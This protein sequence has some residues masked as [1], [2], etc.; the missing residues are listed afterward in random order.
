[1]SQFKI[2]GES[3]HVDLE[4]GFYGIIDRAGNPYF[5]I[6]MPEQYKYQGAKVRATFEK[7]PD[8]FSMTMW[9]EVIRIISFEVVA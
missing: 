5:A 1:M 3:I 7:V 2:E 6:N 8:A 9:G 4:G